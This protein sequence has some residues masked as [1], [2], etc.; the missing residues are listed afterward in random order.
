M[1]GLFSCRPYGTWNTAA[2]PVNGY[3]GENEGDATMA[4]G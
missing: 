2:Y 1:P 3:V 4:N